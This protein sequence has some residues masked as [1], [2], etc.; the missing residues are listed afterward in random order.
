M[1]SSIHTGA[2]APLLQGPGPSRDRIRD[3]A[4]SVETTP[5]STDGTR[6][7][8][9]TVQLENGGSV[10]REASQDES[11]RSVSLTFTAPDGTSKTYSKTVS[12]DESGAREVSGSITG[13]DGV[14]LSFTGSLIRDGALAKGSLDVTRADGQ[15]AHVEFRQAERD[16]LSLYQ[17]R[18]VNFAGEAFN[19]RSGESDTG[20]YR[21]IDESA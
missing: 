18:G 21:P 5:S 19:T 6:G 13:A 3:Q 17:A 2:L 14:A 8:T 16:G 15:T 20:G 4:T 12:V 1:I 11:G 10:V 9:T 7:V